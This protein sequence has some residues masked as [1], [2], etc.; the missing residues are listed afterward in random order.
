MG[1][2]GGSVGLGGNVNISG[3]LGF[4]GGSIYL[5]GSLIK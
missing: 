2:G 1:F 3:Y 5:G 4:G